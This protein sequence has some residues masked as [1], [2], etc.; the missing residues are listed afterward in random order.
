MTKFPLSAQSPEEAEAVHGCPELQ[1]SRST[2]INALQAGRN[3]RL[4]PATDILRS[5]REIIKGRSSEA[6]CWKTGRGLCCPRRGE[7]TTNHVLMPV[8]G[9]Q[10]QSP[11]CCL[12]PA[13]VLA[14][15][16]KYLLTLICQ[17]DLAHR[18][19]IAWGLAGPS[20]PIPRTASTQEVLVVKVPISSMLRKVQVQFTNQLHRRPSCTGRLHSSETAAKCLRL[21]GFLCT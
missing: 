21:K 14:E 16:T 8:S 15:L 10:E 18:F 13:E 6:R 7:G 20:P 12:V 2:K 5:E 3:L 9:D 11:T 17:E 4:S 19:S 1:E